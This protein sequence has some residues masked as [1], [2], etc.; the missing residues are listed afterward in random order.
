MKDLDG[1]KKII[2][3]CEENNFSYKIETNFE[4]IGG[5]TICCSSIRVQSGEYLV[6]ECNGYA[7]VYS[8]A[9]NVFENAEVLSLDR[10]LAKLGFSENFS[11]MEE[12]KIEVEEKL[13]VS[14]DEQST[15]KTDSKS[16]ITEKQLRFI[17]SLIH[18]LG[19]DIKVLKSNYGFKNLKDLD[20]KKANEVISDLITL[21]DGKGGDAW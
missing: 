3:W 1:I 20:R 13:E 2:S 16:K 8:K 18:E 19:V 6:R 17:D 15:S 4:H 21:R 7:G 9:K 11:L 10:A 5:Q 12:E 14:P